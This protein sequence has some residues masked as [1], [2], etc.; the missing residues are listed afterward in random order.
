MGPRPRERV[1]PDRANLASPMARLV[2]EDIYDGR[3]MPGV[4]PGEITKLLVLQQ[5]AKPVNFSGG[6][7]PLT[8]GGTFTL[9]RIVGTVPVEPDGSAYMELPALR[10]L[11]LV[12]LD[13]NDVPVKRMHSFMTLQPGETTSCV[14]C[15]EQRIRTPHPISKDLMALRGR[16]KPVTPIEDV[17]PVLDPYSEYALEAALKL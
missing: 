3:N 8:I 11:F 12:A 15:H 1:I 10:S 2:L 17:P 13:K 7:Q 4:E 5:L 6:M 16:P 9:A 14:G